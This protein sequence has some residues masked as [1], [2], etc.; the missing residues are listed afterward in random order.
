MLLGKCFQFSHSLS[1]HGHPRVLPASSQTTP[2]HLNSQIT[3]TTYKAPLIFSPSP[4]SSLIVF[5]INVVVIFRLG[6]RTSAYSR[7]RTSAVL[8]GSSPSDCGAL[9]FSRCYNRPALLQKLLPQ[10]KI[11]SPVNF[12]N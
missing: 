12:Q 7:I 10:A 6:L 9:G 11:R 3:L 5:T 4:L 2:P 1:V 8:D